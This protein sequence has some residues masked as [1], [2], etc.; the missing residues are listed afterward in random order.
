MDGLDRS[1]C[2]FARDE[3]CKLPPEACADCK[4]DM[5]AS[6]FHASLCI[7]GLTWSDVDVMQRGKA[8]RMR[9]ECKG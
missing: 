6:A 3:T 7:G 9:Y 2:G 4:V 5:A 1:V 8:K